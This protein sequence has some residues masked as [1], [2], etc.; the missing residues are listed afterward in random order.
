MS[1]NLNIRN[2]IVHFCSCFAVVLIAILFVILS[3]ASLIQTS[4]ID[5]TNPYLEIVKYDNDLVLTNLA[6][7]GLTILGALVLLRKKVSIGKINTHFIVGVMLLVTTILSLAW[8][9]QVKSNASGDALMLLNTARDAAKNQYQNFFTSYDFYGNYSYFLYYPYQLGYVFFSEILYR[10]FGTASSDL[11]MQIPNVFAL[12]F[13]YVG[14]VMIAGRI[15]KRKAV[16]N[17]TAIL[18]TVCL[19][20][21]F[22]TTFTAGAVIGLAFAVWGVYHVIRYLQNNKIKNAIFAVVLTSFAVLF[23]FHYII[24]AAAACIALILHIIEKKKFIAIAAA[25]AIILCPIGLQNAVIASYAARSG[26][27]LNTHITQKLY[28]YM[29]VSESSMAPGWFNTKPME[30]LRDAKMDMKK[31][32]EIA[33]HGIESRMT[34]LTTSHQLFD[35]FEKKFLSQF[36][37]PSFES[38]WISQTRSH[39]YPEGEKL[40]AI[41]E[42]VY[43]GGLQKVLDNWFNY[44]TMMI[45]IS[46]TAAMIWLIIRKKIN[47]YTLILPVAVLGGMLYHMISEA[48]SQYFLPYF[49]LLIPF[50]AYG[51]IE[52]VRAINKKSDILFD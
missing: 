4:R 2:R 5:Q 8:I 20:P 37:E 43:S 30:T 40:P 31:A 33:S 44:Y 42:S 18:L 48:K 10:I 28:N 41:V 14:I 25:A 51:L 45:F 6:L 17:L 1:K 46:F 26:A 15:F 29:G 22:M 11:L 23:K 19:Q 39:D 7:I 32:D 13:I 36:N 52:S 21:M 49:I 35:F 34:Y 9:T 47:T 12:D 38:V 50:A 3:F 24:I 16:T 27:S